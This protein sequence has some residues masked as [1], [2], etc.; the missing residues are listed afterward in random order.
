MKVKLENEMLSSAE[1]RER[2]SELL[3]K[4]ATLERERQQFEKSPQRCSRGSRMRRGQEDLSENL[5]SSVNKELEAARD[6]ELNITQNELRNSKNEVNQLKSEVNVL[7]KE[8][9]EQE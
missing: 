3:E 6:L 7:R 9:R 8:L 5:D 4:Y 2:Y 1:F